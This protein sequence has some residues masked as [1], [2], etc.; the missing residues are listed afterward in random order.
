MATVTPLFDEPADVQ[1]S[2]A[3]LSS[4]GRYRYRLWREIGDGPMGTVVFVMLNPST[5]DAEKDDQ[6]IRKC[7]EFARQWSFRRLEV[8]NLFAWRATNPKEL[9]TVE[10]PIGSENDRTIEERCLA[11][12][13]VICAWGSDKFGQRRARVVLESL[14]RLNIH[15]R[16]LRKS[17][18]GHP[19]HPL[20]VPYGMPISL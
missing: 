6:T 2:G 1:R 7:K 11:A 10:E 12:D 17:K 19:W 3:V 4:D 8:V 14:R 13:W 20:Y 18:D 9:P 5:A 15:L 16:C